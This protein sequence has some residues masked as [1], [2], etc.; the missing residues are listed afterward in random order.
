MIKSVAS[1]AQII[2]CAMLL[3]ACSPSPQ[4]NPSNKNAAP[5][6]P[7]VINNATPSS[8]PNFV[9]L[10]KQNGPAV[11]N[12]STMRTVRDS[13]QDAL[14][15][16]ENDPFF[17]FF[18]RFMPPAGPQEFQERTL[19]SGFI[20]SKDGDILTN[21][22]VAMDSDEVTVKLT[23]KR[24]Y[25]A[26]VIGVDQRTDVALIKIN[27]TDL[28]V[29]KIGDPSKLEVGEWVAAIGAPFGF[30]NSVTA[31]IV[32]AKG[33]ALPDGN[34]VPFIQ[35][36]V[37]VNPGN[38]GGPLF[39][40][41][42]EVVGINSQI[43]SRTGGFMGVSFA[44]PIDIAM[45]VVKQLR[46]SGKVTS[47]RIGI[48]AQEMTAELAK[49]FG[50]K[51]ISGALVTLVEKDSPADKA[52]V[53][54]GDVILSFNNKPIQTAADLALSVANTKPG[55]AVPV[56]LWRKGAAMML[57]ITVA[58]TAAERAPVVASAAPQN[59]TQPNQA[60][61]VLGDLSAD[62][63]KRLNIT[64]GVVVRTAIGGALRAGL[65]S[66]DI[67][68]AI[69]NVPIESAAMLDAQLKQNAGNTVALL[70]MRGNVT[71]YLPLNLAG[72]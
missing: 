13:G 10:V 66:G 68:L 53:R 35:T 29:V 60:G 36:D 33:R 71:L 1:A 21:A 26:K 39:N 6:S 18:K 50:L 2:L 16:P 65:Q 37:A 55:T 42:E 41:N 17:E 46:T 24:E 30:E 47:G 69:N 62:Q 31:G 63:R 64:N 15:V 49:S 22:H 51:D 54:P 40:M 9:A 56:Q 45:N 12:I 32:S 57:N 38:S 58:E 61:L 34:F 7:P 14:G 3:S 5:Q 25:K 52:G 59:P 11:V 70:V 8:L 43:Y 27:A 19:G 72:G 48:Q 20:I 28:P 23:N 4:P 44:I 67:I